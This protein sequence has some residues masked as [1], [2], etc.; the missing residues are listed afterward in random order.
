MICSAA[1]RVCLRPL[2]LHH[3]ELHR[4]TK[5]G[6]SALTDFKLADIGEGIYEV[7]LIQWFVKEGDTVNEFDKICEVQSDK[8]N[9]EITSRYSGKIE[10]LCYG[11]GD[12]ARV[13]KPLVQIRTS[14]AGEEGNDEQEISNADHE[15]VDDIQTDMP[16]LSFAPTGGK[17]LLTPAVRRLIKENNLDPTRIV[18]SG[19]D[20]RILKE[21]VLKLIGSA[22]AR[23]P[24]RPAARTSPA[25]PAAAAPVQRAPVAKPSPSYPS[26]VDV[27]VPIR[28]VQRIMVQKMKEANEVP[29]FGYGDE[30]DVTELV[31]IR[32]VLKKSCEE[33]GVKLSYMPFFLKATSIALNEYP[34]LNATIDDHPH[35]T[36]VT[37]RGDHNISIAVDTPSGLI[38]PNVK[39]VQNKSILDLAYDL[40]DITSRAR[41]GKITNA[42][43]QGGTFSLSNI[44]AIGGTYCRPILLVPEV[45]IG[46]LGGFTSVPRYLPDG[47]L[48]RREVMAVSW[49]ADHRV[50]DGATM[51]RFS[52]RWKSMLEEPKRMVLY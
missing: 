29:T 33:L 26:G 19:R 16:V 28:G 38:V 43:L 2:R 7:E 3:A 52:N 15:L 13:G 35:C 11:V 37:H 10:S 45:C 49:S 12:L 9:V 4:L 36:S 8:A 40:E 31:K 1:K 6:F 34:S 41:D 20:G 14:E 42:D 21:D 50:I 44:G 18:G 32:A 39:Q 27:K 22:A 48:T 30:V 24:T 17:P 23:A 5:R 47:T 25:P 51:A 46:A